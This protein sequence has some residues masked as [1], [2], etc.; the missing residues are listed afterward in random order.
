MKLL[1][2]IGTATLATALTACTTLPAGQDRLANTPAA[3]DRPC[4][5]ETGT[6][7]HQSRQCQPGR[8]Y[9]QEDLRRTGATD[10]ADALR[11]LDPAIQ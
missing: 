4:V 10:V 6:R 11:R 5:R 8:V 1:T 3:Y 9:T 2:L 7:V